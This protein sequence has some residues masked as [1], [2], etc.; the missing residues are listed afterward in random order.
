MDRIANR[1][2]LFQ[3]QATT[4]NDAPARVLKSGVTVTPQPSRE[5]ALSVKRPGAK[6]PDPGRVR[7]QSAVTVKD[8]PRDGHFRDV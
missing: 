5:T 1:C 8:A 3:K 6:C 2:C 4:P 7:A